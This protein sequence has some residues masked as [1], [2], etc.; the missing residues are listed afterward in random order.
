MTEDQ[1]E[2]KPYFEDRWRG[3]AGLLGDSGLS[4]S[5]SVGGAPS[6]LG[7]ALAFPDPAGP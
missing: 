6:T 7:D 1:P 4:I 5:G 2:I 3:T